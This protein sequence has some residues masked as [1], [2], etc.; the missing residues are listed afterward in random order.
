[1]DLPRPPSSKPSASSSPIRASWVGDR[2]GIGASLMQPAEGARAVRRFAAAGE[3]DEQLGIAI[4]AVFAPLG[5]RRCPG[6]HILGDVGAQAFNRG[7][8]NG[9]K[10]RDDR[11]RV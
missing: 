11:A 8:V 2:G 5:G 10:V 6:V 9:G 1:M 4:A 7:V 3:V